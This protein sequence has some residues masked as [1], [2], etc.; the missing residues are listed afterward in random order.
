V[1]TIFGAKEPPPRVWLF[2]VALLLT[3]C[4]SA[5]SG[6]THFLGIPWLVSIGTII[7]LI[8]FAAIFALAVPATDRK[9]GRVVRRLKPVAKTIMIVVAVFAAVEVIGLGVIYI[10]HW[11]GDNAIT[12][13][14]LSKSV[15]HSFE[16]ADAMALTQQAAQNLLDGR[17]PYTSAN[18]ITALG[19]SPDAFDKVTP[20][21]RGSFS[22][23]FPYPDSEQ[24]E[25]LWD[26]AIINPDQ[27]PVELETHQNYPAGS[28]LLL[29]PF[30]AIGISDIRIAFILLALPALLYAAWLIKPGMRIYFVLGTALSVEIWNAVGGGDTSLICF[31]FLLLS[32]LLMRRNIWLSALCMGIAVAT[33]Q[34]AW[35][36]LP[37]YLIL[38]L[39]IMG[40]RRALAVVGITAAIFAAFNL[41]FIVMDPGTWLASVAAPLRDAMFPEGVGIITLVSSGLLHVTSPMIF[42][43]LEGTAFVLSIAWYY[44][45]CRRYPDTALALALLPLFFAWRSMWN[46]FYYMDI[47]LLAAILIGTVENNA[48]NPAASSAPI[49]KVL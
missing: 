11:R 28:F 47:I 37:F 34:T 15:L 10:S 20:L 22:D 40:I 48:P 14:S 30:L 26:S 38:I 49:Q 6:L 35:F 18:I 25:Q 41:P 24:L 7:W 3:L 29:A 32:W 12:A 46:Y 2:F 39:R 21:D 23:V 43:I 33:K 19:S 17:N 1:P 9:L 27:V 45:N 4:G 13:S 42:S 16:P 5:L 31:P 44:R 8:W 36:L